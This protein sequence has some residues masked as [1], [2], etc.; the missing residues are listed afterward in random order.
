MYDI[1]IVVEE[2]DF[3]KLRFVLDSFT[4]NISGFDDIHIISNIEVPKKLPNVKYHLDKDVIDFD[5]TRLRDNLTCRAGWYK[6]QF[7]KLFQN[8]TKDNYLVVD[9]DVYINRKIDV[10]KNDKPIFLLGKKQYHIPYFILMKNLFDL[11]KVYSYSFIN[12]IMYFKRDVISH[13]LSSFGVSKD[14]FFELVINEVNRN[15]HN[16]GFSEYELY[17][18]Y[19]TKYLPDSYDYR[20][21]KTRRGGR[22]RKWKNEELQEY[23]DSLKT[24]DYD[25]ITMHTWM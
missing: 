18:N 11:D 5:F 23:I 6:Q 8:V 10:I 24:H 7:I 16:S 14:G 3:N 13:M 21:V 20:F 2:K 22:H 25:L 12:E 4:T 17:G 1:L 19:V 15:N 9:S